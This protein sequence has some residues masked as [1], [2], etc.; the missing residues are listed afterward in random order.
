MPGLH[1]HF[2]AVCICCILVLKQQ[3]DS[4]DQIDLFW[5]FGISTWPA[6]KAEWG[7]I[8]FF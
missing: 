4:L 3:N 5:C 8:N 6:Q 1:A 7:H 2:N